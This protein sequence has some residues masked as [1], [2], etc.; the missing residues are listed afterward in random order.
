MR[1]HNFKKLH[2]WMEAM[3]LIDENYLLTKTLPDYERFGLRSQM[4]RCSVSI[5]SN[6][7]EGS[8]KRTD[9]HFLKYLED[10]L[11]SAFEWETQL[12]VCHRQ[13]F[14]DEE[15]FLK[16]EDQVLKLQSKVSNFMNTL[17]SE[18]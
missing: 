17:D 12:I 13:Q 9:K 4:N 5:A 2:I 7:S 8:S 16:L 11:G 18:N 6:I 15:L 3:N 1:R 14:I 10:S